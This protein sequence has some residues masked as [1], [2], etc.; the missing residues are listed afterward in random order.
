M[1][2]PTFAIALVVL[3]AA[4]AEAQIA[5]ATTGQAEEALRLFAS[6]APACVVRGASATG[7]GVNAT[8]AGDGRGGGTIAIS[9]LVDPGSAEPRASE[10]ELAL[11]VVCNSAHRLVITS[12]DGGLLRDGGN[13]ANGLAPDTFADIVPYRLSA[14]WG[15]ATLSGTSAR[16]G[17]LSTAQGAEAGE[18]RLRVATD[19]GGGVLTAGRYAD[20]ITIR[21]EPAS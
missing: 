17:E 8:F 21:F 5:T 12:S 15:S 20:S 4:P 18:L 11:P 10:I 19:Q 9:Q 3:C 1:R 6:A 14:D 7:N 16:G 2:Q 13:P